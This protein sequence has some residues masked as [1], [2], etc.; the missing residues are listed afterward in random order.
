[1]KKI[2]SEQFDVLVIGGGAAGLMAAGRAAEKGARVALVEKND[3]YGIK[4]L[5]TGNGRCNVTQ[6]ADNMV[7]FSKAYKNGLPE[8]RG[9]GRFLLSA[10]NAFAPS[11]MRAFLAKRGVATKVEKNGKVYPASDQSKDI[12]KT[13]YQY[14][15]ENM[16]TFF[17]TED[18]LDVVR[19]GNAIDRI[20]TKKKEISAEKYILATG[21]KSYPHTGSNGEGFK[22]AHKL[23]HTIIEPQPCL[24]PIKVSE[25]WIEKAQGIS[26]HNVTLNVFQNNKKI[27]SEN[28]DIMLAHYGLSGPAALNISREIRKILS[29]GGVKLEIDLKPELSFEKLDEIIRKDFESNSNKNLGNCL[30]DFASPKML[31]LIIEL[32]GID[33]QLH[34]SRISKEDRRKIAHLFKNMTLTVQELFGFEKA[35]VTSGGISTKEI[36]SRT[37][38]S[39][40]IENLFFAGEVIDADGPTG[41]YNLQ[42]CWSTGF[43]AGQSAAE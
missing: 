23:G 22:W 15:R 8:G 24:V 37:M 1:M 19:N 7:E 38:K 16:V 30:K 42:M 2:I 5:M 32:S 3:R 18:V 39:K 33:E 29:N 36:D 9:Q 17:N 35:M 4:V 25:A 26:A 27:A 20:I 12:V 34:A 31:E 11:D 43:L 13:L 40:L 28:G 21:G 14:C 6:D 10:F 41:G